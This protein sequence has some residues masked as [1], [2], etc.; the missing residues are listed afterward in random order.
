MK[1]LVV[2]EINKYGI[3]NVNLDPTKAGELLIKMAATGVCHSD[4]SF[5]NG[6]IPQPMAV[7]VGHEGAGIADPV[8]EGVAEFE[9]GDHLVFYTFDDAPQ[10]FIDMENNLNAR[11]VILFD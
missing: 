9:T 4:L 2:S 11:G 5:I 10:A 8:G 7:V 3:E 1:A 6:T